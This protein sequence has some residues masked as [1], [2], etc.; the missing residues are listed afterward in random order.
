MNSLGRAGPAAASLC[1]GTQRRSRAWGPAHE[2]MGSAQCLRLGVFITQRR[3][4]PGAGNYFSHWAR[5]RRARG[6]GSTSARDL[7]LATTRPVE[8]AKCTSCTTTRTCGIDQIKGPYVPGS[9][10][11]HAPILE[12]VAHG[13]G[14][15]SPLATPNDSKIFLPP[16]PNPSSF[17]HSFLLLCWLFPTCPL[18]L[19]QGSSSGPPPHSGD[20]DPL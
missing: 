3:L 18:T 4:R 5:S 1:G 12:H 7:H 16:V 6:L 19:R 11:L 14:A 10:L 17:L 13:A 8:E 20:S 9:F 2:P 15:C